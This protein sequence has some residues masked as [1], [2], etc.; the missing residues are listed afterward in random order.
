MT[1]LF[2]LIVKMKI[3]YPH[4]YNMILY[5]YIDS[6]KVLLNDNIINIKNNSF[7]IQLSNYNYKDNN[8]FL[9]YHGLSYSNVTY[10]YLS[11]NSFHQ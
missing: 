11:N 6:S 1:N 3:L 8:L 2:I 10:L 5:F 4:I 7:S 9:L